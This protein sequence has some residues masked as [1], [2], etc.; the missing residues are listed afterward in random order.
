MENKSKKM[1]FLED[2][3]V[4]G[5]SVCKVAGK[6]VSGSIHHQISEHEEDNVGV[7]AAHQGEEFAEG[8]GH[9]SR[10][11]YYGR[12]W[13]PHNKTD[14]LEKNQ[15]QIKENGRH[16][17]YQTENP[18]D[19]SNMFSRW[20]QKQEI[21]KGYAAK[22]AGST[23]QPSSVGKSIKST[24][25][26][27]EEA[28]FA[29]EKMGKA[30]VKHPGIMVFIL[31]S[32]LIIMLIGGIGSSGSMVFSGVSNAVLG[33]SYTAEDTDIHGADTDYR[34]LESD[35][36]AQIDNIES[37]HSGYDEY[38]YQLDEIGH[39][40][41]Q[42]TSAL[43][44][45]YEDFTQEEVQEQLK[46][47][48]DGQ[49]ELTLTEEVEIRTRTEKRTGTSTSRDPE[50]GEITRERYEY[51]VEVEYEYTILNV[52]LTNI[53]LERAIALSGMTDD[54]EERYEVLM[55]TKGNRSYLFED[56]IYANSTNSVGEYTDYDIPGEALTDKRFANM[57][58]EAEKYLG[59][60]YVWG[61]SSPSTGFDCSGFVCYVVNHC[62]NGWNV[63]RQT[64]NGLKNLCAVIP[65][66]EMRP[67]DLVFFQGTYNTSG[68]SHV[69]IYV[70]NGMMIHCGNPLSY[71]SI[72][73]DY[74]LSHYYCAGRLP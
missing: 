38:R 55:E 60:P 45:L 63:G 59:M 13:K 18:G 16:R 73:T 4:L 6:S 51:E 43:T 40:P 52:S 65:K 36:Q 14:K 15:N 74:W 21:K 62:G 47:F 27:A 28:K 56:S 34:T 9:I 24:E 1:H 42:L 72:E 20:R 69:G 22:A 5:R 29:V 57:V 19:G 41:Y 49:Y 53:G 37:T 3:P 54:Q 30:A 64:A 66:S 46:C 25:K 39:D 58:R 7:Q 35:L 8:I 33:T 23:S 17:Q 50:T 2:E 12:K 11:I 10:D 70:G 32:A 67:G 31:V 26:A 48:F 61:G 44:V 68:A 71:A